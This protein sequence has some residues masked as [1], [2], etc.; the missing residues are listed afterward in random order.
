MT[1]V[2]VVGVVGVGVICC[3]GV[4]V[5]VITRWG[6]IYCNDAARERRH[7]GTADAAVVVVGGSGGGGAISAAYLS[8]PW[9]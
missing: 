6:V 8:P 4:V 9:P 5:G 7:R 1:A 3:V 2:G